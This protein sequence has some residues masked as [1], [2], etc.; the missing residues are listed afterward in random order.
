MESSAVRT[1]SSAYHADSS[2]APVDSDRVW[3]VSV[4]FLKK[5]VSKSPCTMHGTR[6]WNA[7]GTFSIGDYEIFDYSPKK[8]GRAH[9]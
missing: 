1:D 9:V 5:T 7:F 3:P 2:A 4:R 6:L 8:I